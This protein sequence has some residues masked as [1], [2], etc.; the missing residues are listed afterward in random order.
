MA[1]NKESKSHEKQPPVHTLP[2]NENGWDTMQDGEVLEHNDT[3]ADAIAVSRAEAI[4]D[5]TEHKIHKLDGKI[6]DS[7]SYTDTSNPPQD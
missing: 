7:E 3:K 1:N 5:R 6:T 2:S 4:K